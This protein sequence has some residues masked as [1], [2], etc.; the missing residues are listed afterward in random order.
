MS[1]YVQITPHGEVSEAREPF[2]FILDGRKFE[3]PALDS[4]NVP[5]PL[6][7][8]FL[9]LSADDAPD[10]DTRMRVAGTFVAYLEAD[11]P[12]LWATLKRQPDAIRWVVGLIEQWGGHSGLDPKLPASGV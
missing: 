8:I 7:P 11:H 3:L 12:K 6:I 2:R 10:E 1:E 5:L 9:A 4:A